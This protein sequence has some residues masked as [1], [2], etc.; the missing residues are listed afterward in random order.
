MEGPVGLHLLATAP[1]PTSGWSGF[2]LAIS[3][4][5][6]RSLLPLLSARRRTPSAHHHFLAPD[7]ID[8]LL[9][10]TRTQT[11]KMIYSVCALALLNAADAF[12]VGAALPSSV[13]ASVARSEATMQVAEAEVASPVALAKVRAARSRGACR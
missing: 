1:S 3:S 11:S 13:R 8:T 10:F 5:C 7:G 9:R 4:L 12:S 2:C 6:G